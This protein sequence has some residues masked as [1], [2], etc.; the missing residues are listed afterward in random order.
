MEGSGLLQNIYET[1]KPNIQL[2]SQ[3]LRDNYQMNGNQPS[4]FTKGQIADMLGVEDKYLRDKIQR[5]GT[6]LNIPL[7]GARGV[8]LN[9]INVTGDGNCGLYAS[10]LGL[11]LQDRE[12]YDR[13]ASETRELGLPNY[14]LRQLLCSVIN[15]NVVR[16]EQLHKNREYFS[17]FHFMEKG[18]EI[19]GRNIKS[20]QSFGIEQQPNFRDYQTFYPGNIDINDIII[21]NT[22]GIGANHFKLIYLSTNKLE[23]GGAAAPD[24]YPD[25]SFLSY[26]K[27][28]LKEKIKNKSEFGNILRSSINSLTVDELLKAAVEA[29]LKL[30]NQFIRNAN[31]TG[32][33]KQEELKNASR[34]KMKEFLKSK[35]PNSNRNKK[36]KN[37]SINVMKDENLFSEK[38][39]RQYFIEKESNQNVKNVILLYNHKQLLRAF[40]QK[41][42]D[43]AGG[44]TRGGSS[45]VYVSK[46]GRRKLRYTKTGRKFIIN[47]GKRKYLK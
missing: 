37:N 32:Q 42:L 39:L 25:P 22:S 2:F 24:I 30:P 43:E 15:S 38:N 9:I 20:I 40:K 41:V 1:L 13:W 17:N 29:G 46:I 26:I 47:K 7:R 34:T 10:L 31:M 3:H 6:F 4:R 44:A 19:L 33:P 18:R 12:A 28:K 16:N 21:I 36:V 23:E 5:Y 45:F 8:F 27:N 14:A 35:I 11:Y